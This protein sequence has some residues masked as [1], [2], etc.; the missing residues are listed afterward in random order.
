MRVPSRTS[1]FMIAVFVL[2]VHRL[3]LADPEFTWV[4]PI[5]GTDDDSAARVATDRNDDVI[6]TGSFSGTISFDASPCSK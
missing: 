6:V 1:L 5:G 2:F 3:A 4:N